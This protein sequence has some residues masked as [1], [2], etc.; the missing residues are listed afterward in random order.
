MVLDSF[1]LFPTLVSTYVTLILELVMLHCFF[2]LKS[3]VTKS[4]KNILY[5]KTSKTNFVQEFSFNQIILANLRK[6]HFF[7]TFFSLRKVCWNLH[8][9]HQHILA[10]TYVK[11]VLI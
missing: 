7:S 3:F 2:K 8:L 9:L 10:F 11:S 5:I 4:E 6:V 1:S